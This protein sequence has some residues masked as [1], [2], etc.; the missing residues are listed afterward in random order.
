MQL[1]AAANSSKISRTVDVP[2]SN[3]SDKSCGEL[4]IGKPI[5]APTLIFT[6]VQFPLKWLSIYFC[7]PPSVPAY[8][9]RRSCNIPINVSKEN[10]EIQN[11]ALNNCSL[12]FAAIVSKIL[13]DRAVIFQFLSFYVGYFCVIS[14][15]MT[16]KA[17]SLLQLSFTHRMDKHHTLFRRFRTKNG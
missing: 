9:E 6:S 11:M 12:I 16:E 13:R 15:N 14:P 3:S 4:P 1:E 10:L 17:E 2:T 5:E 8:V 7:T